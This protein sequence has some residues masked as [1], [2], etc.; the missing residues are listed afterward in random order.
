MTS[1]APDHADPDAK[2]VPPLEVKQALDEARMLV[3]GVQV[4]L[5]FQ[6]TA[7]FQSGFASRKP[8]AARQLDAAA[9]RAPRRWQR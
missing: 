2:P 3:L 5:G 1:R 6:Y 8:A 7:L 4:L 9:P